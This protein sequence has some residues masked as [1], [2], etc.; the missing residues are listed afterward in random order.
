MLKLFFREMLNFA[1]ITLDQRFGANLKNQF[2]G[3]FCIKFVIFFAFLYLF[4]KPAFGVS[5]TQML[6]EIY[7]KWGTG[8]DFAEFKHTLN[9]GHQ[10]KL[11]A[12]DHESI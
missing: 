8:L 1:K 12:L 3:N 7:N 9:L 4:S 10:L 2:F 5:S 6:V 11:P